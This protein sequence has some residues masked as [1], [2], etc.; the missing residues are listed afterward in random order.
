M[1]DGQVS[2]G[3]GKNSKRGTPGYGLGEGGGLSTTE[4]QEMWWPRKRRM[5]RV[6]TH[7]KNEKS[8]KKI[9]PK[10]RKKKIVLMVPTGLDRSPLP[11]GV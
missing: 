7:K 8:G 9:R 2:D 4:E 11:R 6:E 3:S 1:E 10:E 5:T